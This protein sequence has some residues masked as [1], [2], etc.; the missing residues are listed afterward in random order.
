MLGRFL[1]ILRVVFKGAGGCFRDEEMFRDKMYLLLSS[2]RV[3]FG[4]YEVG[5]FVVGLYFF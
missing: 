3:G 4:F 1:N 5:G 2:V